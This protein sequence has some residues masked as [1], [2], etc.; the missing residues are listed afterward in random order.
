M[1][2]L[3]YRGTYQLSVAE[4]RIGI[5]C[6]CER[7]TL[8]SKAHDLII[9]SAWDN[10]NEPEAIDQI[11]VKELEDDSAHDHE[12]QNEEGICPYRDDI[13]DRYCALSA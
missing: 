3:R 13:I 2:I 7:Y 4:M 8:E 5:E 6:S 12:V 1:S 10:S 9:K 11:D